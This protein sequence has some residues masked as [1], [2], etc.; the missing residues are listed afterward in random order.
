M[1]GEKP[2]EGEL[3]ELPW[4]RINP[5]C[6]WLFRLCPVHTESPEFSVWFCTKTPSYEESLITTAAVNADNGFCTNIPHTLC[7]PPTTPPSIW[8]HLKDNFGKKRIAMGL[9]H[10]LMFGFQTYVWLLTYL[11]LS[12]WREDWFNQDRFATMFAMQRWSSGSCKEWSFG[13]LTKTSSSLLPAPSLCSRDL[14]CSGRIAGRWQVL[15][16]NQLPTY[17]PLDTPL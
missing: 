1:V 5:D 4:F 17:L 6:T 8:A 15:A 2:G 12:W 9:L 11:M 10:Y 13:I 3:V 7:H 16:N 14:S